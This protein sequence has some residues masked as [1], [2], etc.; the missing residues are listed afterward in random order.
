VALGVSATLDAYVSPTIRALAQIPTLGWLAV[1][2]LL[3]GLGE[4]LNIVL[5]AKSCFVP[6]V[7][8]TTAAIRGVPVQYREV[9]RTLR[10]R[11]RTVLLRLLLPATLPRLF[12]GVRQALGQA[13]IA[14]VMVEMLADSEGVGY[15]ITWGRTLFQID[16][17][18]SGILVIGIIGLVLDRALAWSERRLQRWS[19]ENA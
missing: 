1:L 13:W 6:V 10:L 17:V 14:L 2:I 11:P 9:A 3:L 12:T 19:P 5:I 15:L 4:P 16:V 18:L 7:L 8:N